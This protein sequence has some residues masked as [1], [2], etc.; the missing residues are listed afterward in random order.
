MIKAMLKTNQT[1]KSV[2]EAES[3]SPEAQGTQPDL[4]D[5][6]VEPE[7]EITEAGT[8][9]DKANAPE[10]AASDDECQP[11]TG[12]SEEEGVPEAGKLSLRDA[13]EQAYCLGAGIDT[14]TLGKAKEIIRTIIDADSD[15]RFNPEALRLAIRLL[16]YEKSLEEARRK[17]RDEG[18][19]EEI[20]ASFRGKR[21]KAKEAAAI[22]HLGGK[23]TQPKTDNSIFDVA[24]GVL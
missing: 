3:N 6:N 23:K 8:P 20:A 21:A 19:A 5:D 15:E 2:K 16:N 14:D 9:D 11:E 1:K 24:R 7:Q 12:A 13:I 22:P 4:R 18:R 10:T 17:G